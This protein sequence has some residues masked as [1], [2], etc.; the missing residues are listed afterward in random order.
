M[1]PTAPYTVEAHYPET[2]LC[3][4]RD[5]WIVIIEDR[6]E[7][8]RGFLAARREMSGPR[9]AY[10]LVRVKDGRVMEALPRRDEQ[11]VGMVAGYP[12]GAQMLG[13]AR[14]LLSRV[15]P[16]GEYVSQEEADI[17]AAAL[18]VLGGAA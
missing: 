13:A 3:P 4:E 8:C 18:A 14:R 16:H 5:H 12:T 15:R 9:P 1:T 10:R 7:F 17:A 11:G 6:L 2:G